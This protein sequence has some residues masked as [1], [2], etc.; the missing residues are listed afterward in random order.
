MVSRCLRWCLAANLDTGSA[1]VLSFRS[2]FGLIA[3]GIAAA[4]SSVAFATF[5]ISHGSRPDTGKKGEYPGFFARGLLAKSPKS[6]VPI[7]KSNAGPIAFRT[8]D[9]DATGSISMRDGGVAAHGISLVPTFDGSLASASASTDNSYVLRFV[10]GEAALLQSD[11]GLY[12][13]RRG[14][15]LP[16]AGRVLSITRL[17]KTWML[18][19]TTRIFRM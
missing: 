6:P 5:M 2:D 11:R 15:M 4:V 12:A 9:Y 8:I 7:N 18:V 19:T 1:A 10:R 3:T 14:T 16:G 13:V 17:G